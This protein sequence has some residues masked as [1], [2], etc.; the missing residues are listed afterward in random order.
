MDIRIIIHRFGFPLL[1]CWNPRSINDLY[2]CNCLQDR[3]IFDGSQAWKI[4]TIFN[5]A[6][7]IGTSA[8][9]HIRTYSLKCQK[10]G[11]CE[12]RLHVIQYIQ[13]NVCRIAHWGRVTHICVG[14]LTIIGSDNG[15]SPG[16]RQAIIRINAGIFLIRTLG[17]NF[18][19]ILKRKWYLFIKE[20]GGKFVS[21]S[22]CFMISCT[23][24]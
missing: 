22:M 24:P 5:I 15:L 6:I 4:I 12:I 16:R 21:A 11:I 13:N 9:L 18:S 8:G 3:D 20:N 1:N 23:Y 10:C 7:V 2:K 14:K 19:E 17:T